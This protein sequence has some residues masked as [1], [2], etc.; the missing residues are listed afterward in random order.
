MRTGGG[1]HSTPP[2]VDSVWSVGGSPLP[3][4]YSDGDRDGN[5][6]GVN[7][8]GGDDQPVVLLVMSIGSTFMFHDIALGAS[9]V[10]SNV[11]AL[12]LSAHLIGA[13]LDNGVRDAL[14]RRITFGFF[15]GERYSYVGLPEFQ[16]GTE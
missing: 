14:H 12:L 6:N 10:A 13:A 1:P 7:G 8:D 16:G 15:Q 11:L 2:W 4:E 5:G 9:G 3:T